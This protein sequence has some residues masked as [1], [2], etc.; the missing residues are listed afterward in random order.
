[1]PRS[2]FL[3]IF[4]WFC[5]VVITVI[6]A[7]FIVGEL[8][9]PQRQRPPRG[10][11]DP[12]VTMHAK[13]A[14]EIFERDGPAG[15]NTYLEGVEEE[16]DLSGFVFNRQLQEISGRSFPPEARAIAQR[17]FERN[18]PHESHGPHGPP[19]PPP[20]L[21]QLATT[22]TGSEYAFVAQLPLRRHA[23]IPA[24]FIH[25]LA[26]CLTG[27]AFCYWLA[28][29]VTSPVKKLRKATR[30]L[31]GGNLSVRVTPA[32]GSRRDE[33][34]SL[35][36]DFDLMAEQIE[37]LITGQRRLLGDIS[38][39]LRS[40]LARLNVALELARQRA[41]DNASSALDRIEREA[42]N[43]N[44]MIGQLLALTRLEAGSHELEQT[45][46]DLADL[47]RQIVDDADFEAH[48][49]RRSVTLTET[50]TC[51]VTG[52]N[53][54]LRRAIENVVR[55]GVQY[56][57]PDTE[58]VVEVLKQSDKCVVAVSDHGPGVPD[59]ALE[60]IFRP[61]YR[62]EDA[63]DR[64]TGGT[65][66]GLAIVDRAVRLHGGT[67]EAVNKAGGGLKVTITLPTSKQ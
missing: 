53:E 36:A 41:G 59:D 6:V 65:G 38:H 49:R 43:L 8:S 46:F 23:P 20:L 55:N 58:V 39:E 14:A 31:A 1:M 27:A 56:T 63:R 32:L 45:Q 28:W 67:V 60:K 64:E 34:T 12:L 25:M 21:V 24:H 62:V 47:V 2:L 54:L 18:L 10:P 19:E 37:T 4:L 7:T 15:L 17:A 57:S 50:E 30:E 40:P 42:E 35:A 11:L 3:K 26:V 13:T 29:Y 22:S 44:E 16:T 48:A 52:N 66:L 33:L 5:T 51:N 9:R 61:F